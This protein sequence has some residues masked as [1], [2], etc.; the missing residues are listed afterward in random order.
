MVDL[1]R[2]AAPTIIYLIR[3][4]QIAA[5]VERRWHGSTNSPLNSL[6]EIQASRLGRHLKKQR[7]GISA[8]YTSPLLR[9]YR[10]AELVGQQLGVK[11]IP[12]DD[13]VEFGIGDLENTLFDD[14][15]NKIGFFREIEA[16]LRYAP[17]GGESVHQVMLRMVDAI[18]TLVSQH[19]GDE[20][21]VV[22][23]GAAISIALAQ[24]LDGSPYPFYQYHMDN[25]GLSKLSYT[26]RLEMIDFNILDHLQEDQLQEDKG[27]D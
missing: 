5:N 18:E 3:H 4:G 15:L 26:S 13:L 22:S 20:I 1:D 25:T 7:P 6:G 27:H 9:T 17:V 10:T 16:D 19:R 2:T 21:A 8:I 12:V 14:L 24:M 11:P 23:H